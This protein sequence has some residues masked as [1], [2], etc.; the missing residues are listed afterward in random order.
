MQLYSRDAEIKCIA[1]L[2]NPSVS[3]AKRLAFM[4][5]L[6]KEF[7]YWPPCE[8]AFNRI[9]K[10]VRKKFNLVDFDDLM[11]DPAL[12]EDFRDQLKDGFGLFQALDRL[13]K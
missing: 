11:E 5:R 3:E 12:Q 13:G 4:G 1:T 10:I 9:D 7:F 8:A 2:T 6:S